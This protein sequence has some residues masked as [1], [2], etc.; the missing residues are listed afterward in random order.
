MN[1]V[2]KWPNIL[3]KILRCS[4]R[5]IFSKY[6]WPFYKIMHERV[7]PA[8]VPYSESCQTPKMEHF[9]NGLSR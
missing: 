3:L 2:V 8:T 1:N 9:K 7:K 5:K 4:H 6:V